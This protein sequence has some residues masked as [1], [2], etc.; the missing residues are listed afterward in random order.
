LINRYNSIN[1]LLR[2][3]FG[4]RVFKVTLEVGSGCP[5]RDGSKGS[6][7]CSFC[8]PDAL[9]AST[10]EGSG[11]TPRPIGQQL[12]EGVEYIFRRHGS[13]R[14]I[15]YL[16]S[17]SNTYMPKGRLAPILREAIAHPAVVGLAVSTRPDCIEDGHVR[18]LGDISRETMLWVELGLQSSHDGSLIR[19]RRGHTVSDFEHA[20]RK[21]KEAG[22]D[23]CAHIVLG[24]PGE[25]PEMMIETARFLNDSGVWGVKIHNLHVLK[26]T[27]LEEEFKRGEVPIPTLDEYAGW[28]TDFLE[29]LDP[30]IVIHRFNSHS[31]RGLTV[32]PEWSVNKLATLN[33]VHA[34]LERRDTFQGKRFAT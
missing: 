22:I 34:E 17:G 14:V 24:L 12:D 4:E 32:A 1:A 6:D 2:G 28:V 15:S 30:A 5:N 19:M 33:A 21:L 11:A 3:R 10:W 16:Q 31:P 23:V 7:G 8:H 18:L 29:E 9:R 13:R 26:D 20:S 27:P 25:T